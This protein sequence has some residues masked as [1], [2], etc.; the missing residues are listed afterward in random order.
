MIAPSGTRRR[1][2]GSVGDWPCFADRMMVVS[3]ALPVAFS[4]DSNEP[5]DAS[6]KPSAL[7]SS[8]PGTVPPA[9]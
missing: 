6:M 3:S 2:A 1:A 7:A 8:G 5:T 4:A 9:R